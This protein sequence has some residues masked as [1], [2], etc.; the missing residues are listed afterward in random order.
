MK[1]RLV[2]IIITIF[3]MMILYLG[4][5]LLPILYPT[6]K[7]E[8]ATAY[9]LFD[10][11][12]EDVIVVRDEY[13]LDTP[14][15]V[16]GY[17]AS[18]GSRI[19]GGGLVAEVFQNDASAEARARQNSF[20]S[21]LIM[22]KSSQDYAQAA[23]GD[24]DI[25]LKQQQDSLYDLMKITD[26]GYYGRVEDAKSQLNLISNRLQIATGE[27]AGFDATIQ[28]V[29]QQ[30]DEAVGLA[31][32]ISG[33]YASSTGYYSHYVD[34]M[35]DVLSPDILDLVDETEIEKIINDEYKAAVRTG[36][37]IVKEY[38]SYLYCV[39]DNEN[40]AALNPKQ[41]VTLDFLF[42]EALDV[43]AVINS[44]IAN[45]KTG[46]SIVKIE[47]TNMSAQTMN[48]RNEKVVIKFKSYEGIRVDKSATH[49][50][51]DQLVVY[52]KHGDVVRERKINPIFENDEYVLLPMQTQI[53]DEDNQVLLYDDIII[54]GRDLYDN[55]LI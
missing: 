24:V 1:K 23:E 40:A 14:E 42:T 8:I 33:I 22:L 55:K 6:F 37:K 27:T 44:V 9:T 20:E 48:L 19:A 49:I 10:G 36:G 32:D 2:A 43:P 15:G 3:I 17:V 53:E 51:D 52:I 16:L 5:Q 26:H 31:G 35:E 7:T 34:G 12:E 21:Q 47:C 46:N 25:I 11:I 28:T 13:T 30:R 45:L 18:E 50:V 38:K 39:M 54:S 41:K 4:Y 29:T